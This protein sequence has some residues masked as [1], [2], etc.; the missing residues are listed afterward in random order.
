MVG[1]C[2]FSNIVRGVFQACHLGYAIS[3]AHQGKE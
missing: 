1:V 2:N 3:L